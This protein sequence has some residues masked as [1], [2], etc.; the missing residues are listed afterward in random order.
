MDPTPSHPD[1]GTRAHVVGASEQRLRLDRFLRQVRPDLSRGA[2]DRLL[3]T[4]A[5]LV[6]GVPRG[7]DYFVRRGERI[8]VRGETRTAASAAAAS[9]EAASA[10]P[11]DE[12]MRP[13]DGAPRIERWRAGTGAPHLILRTPHVL[14]AAKPPGM[15]T[16]P[17]VRGEDSLLDWARAAVGEA[18]GAGATHPPGVLHRL[19]RDASGLVLF[20]LAPEGH[21]LVVA[22]MRRHRVERS[23]FVLVSGRPRPAAGE[24]EIALARNASGRVVAR[25]DGSPALT[26]YRTLATHRDATLL[27][28]QPQTGRMHQIRVHFA[29]IGHPVAG[30][31]LYGD[32]RATLD[33]PRLWLHAARLQFQFPLARR[34][35]LPRE[36]AC[37]LWEDLAGHLARLGMALPDGPS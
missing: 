6:E 19:D 22:A 36:V 4:G 15:T 33:A 21:R 28:A 9:A 1:E 17:A 18:T 16:N 5:V 7:R 8:E 13:G 23:Y 27:E 29:A 11:R 35:G 2:I 24:I 12:R 37:P 34:L 31:P 10:L 25:E 14:V 26:R 30:D 3:R 32:P 20:S